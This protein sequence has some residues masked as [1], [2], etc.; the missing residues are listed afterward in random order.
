MIHYINQAISIRQG[1]ASNQ[2]RLLWIS[3]CEGMW[4]VWSLFELWWEFGYHQHDA[5]RQGLD[6]RRLFSKPRQNVVN[7]ATTSPLLWSAPVK[8]KLCT[9]C[10]SITATQCCAFFW[11]WFA[12]LLHRRPCSHGSD[13]QSNS[14]CLRGDLSQGYYTNAICRI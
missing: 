9:I 12:C 6:L 3:I 7:G 10:I 13:E 5:K 2:W 8:V 14:P 4:V 11:Q 1:N